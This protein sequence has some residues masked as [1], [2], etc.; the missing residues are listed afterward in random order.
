M[1]P[2]MTGGATTPPL[3]PSGKRRAFAVPLASLPSNIDRF[4]F[5]PVSPVPGLTRQFSLSLDPLRRPN[6]V[7]GASNQ[8]AMR[9]V[10]A[11]GTFVGFQREEQKFTT[12]MDHRARVHGEIETRAEYASRWSSGLTVFGLL[13][14]GG[15]VGVEPR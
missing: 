12:K 7:A 8:A 5:P 15:G 3:C 10:L 1:A 11:T 2:S 6:M 14:Q 9:E 13:T 4:T